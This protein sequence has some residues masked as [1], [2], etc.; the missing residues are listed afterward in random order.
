[1]IAKS[2]RS[3]SNVYKAPTNGVSRYSVIGVSQDTK[4]LVRYN[5]NLMER[6][7]HVDECLSLFPVTASA[8]SCWIGDDED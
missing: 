1:M 5:V 7:L 8:F 4:P 6:I 3:D 2:V